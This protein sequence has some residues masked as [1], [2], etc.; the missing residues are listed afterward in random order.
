M[1]RH[2]RKEVKKF[3]FFSSKIDFHSMVDWSREMRQ[4]LDSLQDS[5][6]KENPTEENS[7]EISTPLMST[8]PVSV[9]SSSASIPNNIN[10]NNNNNNNN[11]M[12]A[13]PDFEKT[14]ENKE[15]K[16]LGIT[17]FNLSAKKV[18]KNGDSNF[19]KRI[20]F[21]ALPGYEVVN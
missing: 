16:L 3:F 12:P 1:H 2:H 11:S 6:I 5:G 17:K 14:K 19:R 7:K 15:K 9:N 18:K 8:T 20:F 10:N 4:S 21:F 13:D